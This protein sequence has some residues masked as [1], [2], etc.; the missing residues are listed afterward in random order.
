[1]KKQICINAT[2]AA[3]V[4]LIGLFGSPIRAAA[5][6]APAHQGTHDKP[7]SEKAATV[8]K[9]PAMND[10]VD[11]ETQS[12][13][14]VVGKNWPEPV[15]DHMR[16]RSLLV[17]QLEYQMNEGDDSLGWDAVGWYGGDYNRL[18]LKTEGEWRVSGER[19]HGCPA[20]CFGL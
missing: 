2:L 10:R 17:N 6:P 4:S 18:W 16:F 11:V 1:M 14:G 8:A 13:P 7:T 5:Q 3:T 9:V 19:L 12:P 15:E 20:T